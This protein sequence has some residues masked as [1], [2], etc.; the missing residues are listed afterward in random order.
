MSSPP[1]E[2]PPIPKAFA[3]AWRS[4]VASDAEIAR[5]YARFVARRAPQR[6]SVRSAFAWLATGMLL[7][8]G[9]VYAASGTLG[10]L[11]STKPPSAPAE[12][13]Q[14]ASPPTPRAGAPE[15]SPTPSAS[16][17]RPAPS[18]EA[19]APLPRPVRQSPSAESWQRV[20]RGL[21][22][23]DLETADDALLKL[24]NQGSTAEREVATL[25][26]AQV[27]IRQGRELEART[28][29]SELS[30]SATAANTRE[31]AASLL[32]ELGPVPPSQ[33]SFEPEPPTN[34][35]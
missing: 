18:A 27:L 28:L 12:S 15:P 7:G 17:A 29:L 10:L 1:P 32:A 19:P 16:E 24:S 20:A 6:I 9:S 14:R 4:H 21:R 26:R 13:A 35:P 31:K 5:S 25:V 3:E 23:S 2:D 22:T 34:A 11:R 33:R 30:R 8:M